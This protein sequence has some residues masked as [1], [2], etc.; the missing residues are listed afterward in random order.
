MSPDLPH[1]AVQ[2]S[3]VRK[4]QGTK[5][6]NDNWYVLDAEDDDDL[7]RHGT[8][9]QAPTSRFSARAGEA[10]YAP[11]QHDRHDS[12]EPQ[13]AS[14]RQAPGEAPLYGY[15]PELLPKPLGMHP[16][17]PPEPHNNGGFLSTREQQEAEEYRRREYGEGVDRAPTNASSVYSESA[18]SL[19]S[20]AGPATPKGKYYGNLAA[21]T[22]GVRG[23]TPVQQQQTSPVRGGGQPAYGAYGGLWPAA[24]ATAEPHAKSGE[25]CAGGESH[26]R[27]Y[28]G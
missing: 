19:K 14:P 26:G 9:A 7:S 27:G 18:P 13:H 21:A 24:I 4:E 10:R 25:E 6:L 3:D 20:S 5:L 15:A 1:A 12:F 28:C 16:P 2:A 22:R 8:P 23:S 11:I 17:S